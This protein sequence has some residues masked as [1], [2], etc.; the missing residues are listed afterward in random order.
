VSSLTISVM[1]SVLLIKLCN[2]G[3]EIIQVFIFFGCNIVSVFFLNPKIECNEATKMSPYILSYVQLQ[4]V[5][6]SS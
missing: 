3:V 4:E 5:I 6:G 2:G 1:R